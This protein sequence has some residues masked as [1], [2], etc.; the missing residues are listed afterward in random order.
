MRLR[1]FEQHSRWTH[2]G[3]ALALFACSDSGSN[4]PPASSGSFAPMPIAAANAPTA[5]APTNTAPATGMPV[6]PA[7]S[8]AA[9]GDAAPLPMPSAGASGATPTS[10]A[11]SGAQPSDAGAAA[12]DAG[13][14]PV[15]HGPVLPPLSDPGAK[16]PF[17]VERLETLDGLDSHG[18]IAPKELGRDGIKH[19][20]LVWINGASAGFSSYREMLDNVAS[21]GFFILSDK[22]SGFDSAPEV[23]AQKAAIDWAISQAETQGS[24]WFGLLDTTRIA[25]G[26]HSLGSVSSFG[27]VKDP[28]VKTSVHMAGGL[29]GNPEGVDDSWI[30]QLHAPTAF[31]CGTRDTNGLPRVKND[32]AA[33]PDGVPVFFGQLAGV[34]HTDEFDQPNG[35]RWGRILIAWLRWQLA[36]DAS[37]AKAFVG[38]DC[39]FCQGDWTAQKKALD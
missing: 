30:G 3:W 38:A 17:T 11:G 39:E 5:S 33:V 25:I 15:S 10:S 9:G 29:V 21:H 23:A 20:I 37:Y 14:V 34:G 6:S 31:L 24:P 16:G 35:G 36:D 7:P 26:G 1:S 12:A 19:P 8:P 27:N 22:Q 32:F 2:A 28:R 18:I 13:M 4:P